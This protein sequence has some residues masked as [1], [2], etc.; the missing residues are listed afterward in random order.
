[1][2]QATP[3]FVTVEC[4]ATFNA[5]LPANSVKPVNMTMNPVVGAQTVLTVPQGEY[6]VVDDIF[7]K[8]TADV[9]VESIAILKKND[10]EEVSRFGPLTTLLVSNPSRPP[11]PKPKPVYRPGE[12][13]T[14]EA[15]NLA[16]IGTS[17]VTVKFY[18]RIAIFK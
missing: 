11:M 1:M 4:T 16:A 15:I 8:D 17:D 7:I 18:M 2:A 9:G 5:N 14:M 3:Y 13:L 12:R 10:R 6:W